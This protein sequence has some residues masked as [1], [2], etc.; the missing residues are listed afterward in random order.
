[1]TPRILILDGHWNKSVAAIRS[2]ARAGYQVSVA[3]SSRL[4]AGMLSRYPVRRITYPAPRHEPAAFLASLEQQVAGNRYDV[5]LPMELATLLLIAQERQRFSPHVHLPFAEYD[6]L[7]QAAGKI[8]ASTA[9]H[10]A[11]I[12]GPAWQPVNP[13]STAD[14]LADKLG[15][16]L[17][18]KPDMG[19]GGRGLIYCHNM[20]ELSHALNTIQKQPQAYLAQTLV[21][22]G[23][24]GLGVS[25]L[26][27]DNQTVLASFTHKRLREFPVRGGPSSLRQA[28]HHLQAEEDAVTLLKKIKFSGVAMVEFK[29]EP[30]SNQAFFLEINPRFWGSLPLAIA[31]GVDFPVLLCQWTMGHDFA[32]PQPEEGVTMR[33]LLPGDLLHLLASRGRVGRDFW[34]P[35]IADDLLSLRDPGPVVGRLLSPLVALWDPQL[36]SVFQKRE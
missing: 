16:P 28:T 27:D 7:R 11:G 25:V 30:V 33:N 12:A 17:V 19:E 21:A 9:A 3:E 22:E 4:A 31:A 2:L 13:T 34:D 26:M 15:L 8:A 35:T 32:E 36:R 29:V 14:Q 23:G 24:Y 5:V 6:I 1:M 20:A 18:L 10:S